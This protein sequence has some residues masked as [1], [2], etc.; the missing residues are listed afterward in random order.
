[1]HTKSL[2]IA[3]NMFFPLHL[4][5]KAVAQATGLSQE[6]LRQLKGK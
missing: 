2:E 1:M 4:D 6:E 3:K 5:P